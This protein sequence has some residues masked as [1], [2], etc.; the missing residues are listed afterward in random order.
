M[1]VQVGKGLVQAEWPA[2]PVG[3]IAAFLAGLLRRVRARLFAMRRSGHTCPYAAAKAADL[4]GQGE[5]QRILAQARVHG[6]VAIQI[7]EL[8]QANVGRREDL[9]RQL[10]GREDGNDLSAA[11]LRSRI[12]EV[13]R[14]ITQQVAAVDWH[15][16]ESCRLREHVAD[17]GF[18]DAGPAARGRGVRS[19]RAGSTS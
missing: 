12:E 2:T 11:W 15:L 9:R 5:R 18:P 10:I 19:H 7:G 13:D 6:L 3:M 17:V 16:R 1:T 14:V 4:I 8:A